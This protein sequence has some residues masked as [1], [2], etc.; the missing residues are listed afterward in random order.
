MH[1]HAHMLKS[2]LFKAKNPDKD[3]FDL[4]W[5]CFRWIGVDIACMLKSQ[6]LLVYMLEAFTHTHFAYSA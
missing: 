4:D 5:K 6:L 2:I 3:R 1:T